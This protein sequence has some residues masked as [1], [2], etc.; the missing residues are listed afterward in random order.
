MLLDLEKYFTTEEG[1][2]LLKGEISL[3]A[4][5]FIKNGFKCNIQLSAIQGSLLERIIGK[6]IVPNPRAAY[7][8]HPISTAL[9]M[10]AEKDLYSR[11]PECIEIGPSPASFINK[12]PIGVH[13]CFK[14]DNATDSARFVSAEFGN[15]F[16]ARGDAGVARDELRRA[17]FSDWRRD[18]QSSDKYCFHGAENCSIKSKV[19]ISNHSLYD[20]PLKTLYKIM[21]CHGIQLLDAYL[22]LPI[23]MLFMTEF[24]NEPF[25]YKIKK[26]RTIA[27]REEVEFCFLNDES[28]KYIHDF[29]TWSAYLTTNLFQG[30]RFN[31]VMEVKKRFGPMVHLRITRSYEGGRIA[32]SIN[33]DSGE[34]VLIPD[35]HEFALTGGKTNLF[36]M[37][38]KRDA[39][40]RT[41][42]YFISHKD[43]EINYSSFA[44]HY[45]SLITGLK[46][47]NTT[48]L[49]PD[50]HSYREFSRIVTSLYVIALVER[51]QRTKSVG[52][53]VRRVQEELQNVSRSWCNPKRL[54]YTLKTSCKRNWHAFRLDLRFADSWYRQFADAVKQTTCKYD[55]VGKSTFKTEQFTFGTF[56]DDWLLNVGLSTIKTLEVED[57]ASM[58][59][60]SSLRSEYCDF[61]EKAGMQ[62]ELTELDYDEQLPESYGLP[63]KNFLSFLK[64]NLRG[65]KLSVERFLDVHGLQDK[66]TLAEEYL[67]ADLNF[68]LETMINSGK[69]STYHHFEG[70]SCLF[71]T[72]PI[73]DGCICVKEPCNA[74][75]SSLDA[76]YFRR[77]R[78]F[79]ASFQEVPSSG[80]TSECSENPFEERRRT[81]EGL[82]GPILLSDDE[83]ED[84]DEQFKSC[85][86]APS[87]TKLSWSEE[88]EEEIASEQAERARLKQVELKLKAISYIE[89]YMKDQETSLLDPEVVGKEGLYDLKVDN[90]DMLK[91]KFR[92]GMPDV[93]FK[94]GIISGVPGSGK[95]ANIRNKFKP[96]DVVVGPVKRLRE[97]YDGKK[98]E[99][100]VPFF[101][102]EKAINRML[103]ENFPY[104]RIFLDEFTLLHPAV[105]II[106]RWLKSD[107]E[108]IL[109]GD[110]GQIWYG[111]RTGN[112]NGIEPLWEDFNFHVCERLNCSYTVPQDIAKNLKANFKAYKDIQTH[113]EVQRSVQIRPC[114]SKIESRI[115]T[116]VDGFNQWVTLTQDAKRRLLNLGA[117]LES[118]GK[119]A[120][121]LKNVL[122]A[123]EIQGA[124]FKVI[125]LLLTVDSE[126]LIKSQEN[127][128]VTAITRHSERLVVW[129]ETGKAN[130]ILRLN[131]NI[132]NNLE[133]YKPLRTLAHV[134]A[135][136]SV[137][138]EACK[139]FPPRFQNAT[140]AYRCA[141]ILQKI[142]TPA[143][144]QIQVVNR[145]DIPST[146]P[147]GRIADSVKIAAPLKH[148]R[149]MQ[150]LV[151]TKTYHSRSS[152]NALK[153]LLGRD[154]NKRCNL[155]NAVQEEFIDEM[156]KK[157]RHYVI[158]EEQLAAR[159]NNQE[160]ME[161]LID[162]CRVEFLQR[163]QEKGQENVFGL[164][165]PE[166]KKHYTTDFFQKTIEK[167]KVFKCPPNESDKNGQ[168]V[169]AMDKELNSIS[170]VFHRA[171]E[172]MLKQCCKK[173]VV[174]ANGVP[175]KQLGDQV[176]PLLADEGIDIESD[177]TE[178]G[179]TQ[180]SATRRAELK[181]YSILG[182]L[183]QPLI[184]YHTIMIKRK[185]Q[186]QHF[187]IWIEEGKNDGATNTLLGNDNWCILVNIG[188]WDL[189]GVKFIFQKG[190]DNNIRADSAKMNK[191]NFKMFKELGVQLKIEEDKP[192]VRFINWFWEPTGSYPDLLY[193][194]IKVVSKLFESEEQLKE[195]Q[196]AVRDCLHDL[197]THEEYMKASAC[198][199]VYWGIS[200]EEMNYLIGYL[201]HF[202]YTDSHVLWAKG[203]KD[204]NLDFDEQV[205]QIQ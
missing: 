138:S 56:N 196:E 117:L 139:E 29:K 60:F 122:T 71:C 4:T 46:V 186:C 27:G 62:K 130:V 48:L 124:R 33:W 188:V 7:S 157:W 190:D 164:L 134:P 49:Q 187:S 77:A 110:P 198:A 84:D 178:C 13:G 89:A 154:M 153:T 36:S 162:E 173:H 143:T 128:L 64:N 121:G 148:G 63:A 73:D 9:L 37:V 167:S 34:F 176:A 19:A 32:K 38:A 191:Y 35:I 50:K 184:A 21:D 80:S 96:G 200:L 182:V 30:K 6:P 172:K 166:D 195:Y 146:E 131:N 65:A 118:K 151:F 106:T 23:E 91:D 201:N 86:S 81:A 88:M 108:I 165:N 179:F 39:V 95:S 67:E 199:S 52:I 12:A 168:T 127:Q 24:V 92:N 3:I 98:G 114:T 158:D 105:A 137:T 140:S 205:E 132:D 43:D 170:A 100:T 163:V 174:F 75:Q 189:R 150:N 109:A 85:D 14:P 72:N 192:V 152:S 104:K 126:G 54:W 161:N 111:D 26:R 113:S 136:L 68:K 51:A 202:A 10:F 69:T 160:Y 97:D 159:V 15:S 144:S 141:E 47:G 90:L 155:T 169:T 1:R 99:T 102:Y 11:H 156:V 44:V 79:G 101:T 40:D 116:G 59:K 204:V 133:V 193:R 22:H 66:Y 74:Y 181:I 149:R 82:F 31:M 57:I 135:E 94:F 78:M 70:A 175:E 17:F 41:L 61:L 18:K 171:A 103:H 20:I 25:G 112:L 28:F 147:S 185:M 5:E 115:R 125:N 87:T 145:A 93:D 123:T 142:T 83:I 177:F 197:R 8:S 183:T 2:E 76:E 55:D 180:G 120:R 16:S 42:S 194:C 45:R 119:E 53:L 107:S 129:D 58:S 203:F